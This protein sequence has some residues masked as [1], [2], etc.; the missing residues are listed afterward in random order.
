MSGAAQASQTLTR[1]ESREGTARGNSHRN[2]SDGRHFLLRRGRPSAVARRKPG[3]ARRREP[4]LLLRSE[5]ALT[6]GAR[7]SPVQ[8]PP[9]AQRIEPRDVR[10]VGD[11]VPLTAPEVRNAVHGPLSGVVPRRA[12]HWRTGRHRRKRPLVWQDRTA[13]W[14][15]QRNWRVRASAMGRCWPCRGRCRRPAR[16]F[17]ST[18]SSGIRRCGS[19]ST[20]RVRG[21]VSSPDGKDVVFAASRN[22][23]LA[24]LTRN[25][26][27]GSGRRTAL[28]D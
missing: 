28:E 20:R 21:R 13:A 17:G 5:S 1:I 9:V 12:E 3:S 8:A 25:E 7:V 4:R 18:T 6:R 23:V 2:V 14:L 24:E 19:R 22:G 15:S 16:T 10:L 26:T 11:P 27:T